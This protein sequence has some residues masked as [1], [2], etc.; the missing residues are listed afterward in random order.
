MLKTNPEEEVAAATSLDRNIRNYLPVLKLDIILTLFV[1]PSS[2][3][4]LD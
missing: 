2:G 4:L 1:H 3:I